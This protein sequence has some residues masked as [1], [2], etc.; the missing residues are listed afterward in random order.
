MPK[1][2]MDEAAPQ[3][4]Y[5]QAITN[6]KILKIVVIALVILSIILAITIKSLFPLKSTEL[7]VVEYQKNTDVFV[8]VY[9]PNK[10]FKDRDIVQALFLRQYVVARETV[11]RITEV[12]RYQMVYRSSSKEVWN[13]FDEQH[14]AKATVYEQKG[15]KRRIEIIR[16]ARLSETVHQVEYRTIDTK[17]GD[18]EFKE[19]IKEWVVTMRYANNNQLV[20]Y[21]DRYSNPLGTQVTEYSISSRKLIQGGSDE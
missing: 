19:I 6:N 11:D 15:V 13:N 18:P 3:A 8:N 1:S 14:K 21:S 12:K 4:A 7:Q 16:D 10:S 9:K 5:V 17:D 20:K 2:K